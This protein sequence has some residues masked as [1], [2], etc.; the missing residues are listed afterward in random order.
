[1]TTTHNDLDVQ[2]SSLIGDHVESERSSTDMDVVV[3]EERDESK[4][5]SSSNETSTMQSDETED[6]KK[7]DRSKKK[8]EQRRKRALEKIA[9]G[10][11]KTWSQPN[12]NKRTQD[13]AG[14]TWSD[15]FWQLVGKEDK[16]HIKQKKEKEEESKETE[17]DDEGQEDNEEGIETD[18]TWKLVSW[19]DMRADAAKRLLQAEG[20]HSMM[21]LTEIEKLEKEANEKWEVFY[22]KNKDRFFKS[23]RYLQLEFPELLPEN[24]TP[25][26]TQ[27]K[28]A[29]PGV[30][31]FGAS[32]SKTA[33][34]LPTPTSDNSSP[35]K[36]ILEVGCGAGN[37]L[38]PIMQ[39]NPFNQYY[40]FDFSPSAVELVKSNSEFDSSRCKAF[41][42]DL[43][44]DMPQSDHDGFP[45]A[46]SIDIILMIFVL[47]AVAP[48][49]MNKAL[50][51]LYTLLRPGGVILFRD[52]G[53]YDMTQM[54]FVS[55]GGRKL[56]ENF[57]SRGDGTRTYFFSLEA[58]AELF[59]K[60]GF[61]QLQLEYDTRELR[62]RKRKISMY[63][64]WT[65]GKFRKPEIK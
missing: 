31:R 44:A 25:D 55:K 64:V 10:E 9:K 13:G 30:A 23:R 56:G 28:H 27:R 1:M 18:R 50:S 53:L 48:E 19:D 63:R 4:T 51:N 6:G 14:D 60:A 62:N 43:T 52:Y 7:K 39:I 2:E 61:E 37:T 3:L 5:N 41:V 8:K 49:K 22:Q 33:V 16:K 42:F 46:G 65:V 15:S 11:K 26:L 21:P 36:N 40:A 17:V 24:P 59:A 29:P 54:R 12:P 57:Y 38:F 35:K 45:A 47:S 32:S 34:T 58:A 20:E